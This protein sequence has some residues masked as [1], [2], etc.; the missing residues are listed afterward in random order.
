MLRWS[1]TLHIQSC[2]T[3]IYL[4]RPEIKDDGTVDIKARDVSLSETV[5]VKNDGSGRI[6]VLSESCSFDVRKISVKF[7]GG[8]RLVVSACICC[9]VI[10]YTY[11]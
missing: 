4:S 7:H 8:A 9:N 6:V 11:M 2:G 5:S 1:A 10:I 3:Y